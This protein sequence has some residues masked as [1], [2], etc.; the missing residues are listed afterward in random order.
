ML[1]ALGGTGLADLSTQGTSGSPV[2]VA[3]GNGVCCELA[4]IGT[5]QILGDAARHRRGAFFL[6]AG[7]SAL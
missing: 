2:L 5:C 4:D 1:A 6:Q 7:A 3:P